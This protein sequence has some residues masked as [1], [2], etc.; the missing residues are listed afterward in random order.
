MRL[1][2]MVLVAISAMGCA[3]P[4]PDGEQ[5][6]YKSAEKLLKA[7]DSRE[8]CRF[9]HEYVKRYPASDKAD[10]ALQRAFEIALSQSATSWGHH[11]LRD[12]L[13]EF[14]AAAL[15]AEAVFKVGKYHFEN[16]EYDEAIIKF[17]ALIEDYPESE[18]LE[19]AVFLTGDSQL[20]LY[21]GVDYEAAPLHGAREQYNLLLRTFPAGAYAKRAKQ[22]LSQISNELAKRDYLIALYYRKHGKPVSMKVYLNSVL[23]QYPQ[24]EYARRA[25]EMLSPVKEPEN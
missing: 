22:R 4:L 7:R 2:V 8:A 11:R 23:K 5:E 18:R 13:E 16:Q 25:K 24:T 15:A 9:Y 3:L 19:A 17:K 20:G 21:E 14:P 12:L 6:H 1:A 10:I